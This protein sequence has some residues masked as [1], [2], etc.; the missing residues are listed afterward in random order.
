MYARLQA[1]TAL[2]CFI[3]CLYN[4]QH[5]CTSDYFT[6]LQTKSTIVLR[7]VVLI[8]ESFYCRIK[9]ILEDIQI[10]QTADLDT[11]N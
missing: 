1:L 8:L 2:D 7:E 11:A 5:Q 6:Q 3:F 9:N 4:A 10:I